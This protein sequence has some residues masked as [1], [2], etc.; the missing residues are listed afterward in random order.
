[1]PPP[2]RVVVIAHELASGRSQIPA[3]SVEVPAVSEQDACWTVLRRLRGDAGAPAL[4]SL[5]RESLPYAT[6]DA[7]DGASG[8]HELPTRTGPMQ[9]ELFGRRWAA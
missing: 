4:R 7:L 1:V 6:A 2:W 8:V 3:A 9:L 5:I